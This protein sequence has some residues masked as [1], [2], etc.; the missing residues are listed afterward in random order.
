M[1]LFH[2]LLYYIQ[3]THYIHLRAI[4]MVPDTIN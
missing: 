2:I 4:I 3:N 1:F